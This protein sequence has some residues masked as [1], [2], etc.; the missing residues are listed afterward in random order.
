MSLTLLKG[1]LYNKGGT[2]YAFVMNM[3]DT[4]KIIIRSLAYKGIP[5]ENEIHTQQSYI[6]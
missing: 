2:I 5:D 3:P 1:K 4:D 6:L